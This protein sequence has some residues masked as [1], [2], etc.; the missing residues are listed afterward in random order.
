MKDIKIDLPG[1]NVTRLIG[2]GGFAKVY[3]AVQESLER[4]VALKVMEPRMAEESEFCERFLKEGKIVAQL[5]DHP[6][7]VPIFDIG[8]HQG[9]YYMAMEYVGAGTLRDR[10]INHSD[11]IDIK[12]VIEQVAG[13]LSHA[14]K[15]GF[16]H[17]DVKPANIL[18]SEEGMAMLT[19]F[20]IAKSLSSAATRLTEVGFT[21]GTPEYM[22]PEQILAKE[23]DGRTDLYSFGVIIYEM[24]TGEKPFKGDDAF[25][26]ALKHINEPP[27]DLP[28]GLAEY[29]R[30]IDRLLAK[31]PEE[32]FADADELVRFLKG[33]DSQEHAPTLVTD[34]S[35]NPTII[36]AEKDSKSR[37]R[38]WLSP[39]IWRSGAL[40][41]AAL[42]VSI[43]WGF[44]DDQIPQ[45]AATDAAPSK[46]KIEELELRQAQGNVSQLMSVAAAHERMGRLTK[47]PGGNACDAYELVLEI[48]PDNRSAINAIERIDCDED[49]DH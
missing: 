4:T 34:A 8:K 14:H 31:E 23:M 15:R 5:G 17:R 48:D 1:Y 13:A 2:K 32:R 45:P 22:S 24:L 16:I 35:E 36:V 19:D 11:P 46:G 33:E 25:A 43:W 20:G 41:V 9:I 40:A 21:V 39:L 49:K 12:T 26:T 27:P 37:S 42:A 30:L 28:D 6:N 38:P 47:P 29:Q 7:I 10:I 3:L 18:F 44:R